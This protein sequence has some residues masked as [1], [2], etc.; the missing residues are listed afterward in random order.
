MSKNRYPIFLSVAISICVVVLNFWHILT[1]WI[2]NPN[3]RTFTWI[4]HY[5][6]DFFLYVSQIAQGM[7]GNWITS[8]A[9]YTNEY[10][11]DTWVYWPNVLIGKIGSILPF[12]PFELYSFAL[13][14]FVVLL[15]VLLYIIMKELFPKQPYSSLLAFFFFAS[16]SNFSDIP[17]LLT[18]GKFSQLFEMWFS[19]TPA[20]NRF[21]GVPHQTLQTILLLLTI[22]IFSRLV[23]G[24]HSRT[25][26]FGIPLAFALICFVTA[27]ITPIQMLLVCAAIVG[28]LIIKKPAIHAYIS[29][30]IG[31]LSAA[32]GAFVVNHAFDA[33][34]LY[35]AAKMWEASQQVRATPIDL[36][37]A[38]GPIIFFLPF[39]IR[40][41]LSQMT[42]TRLVFLLYGISSFTL[43]ATPLPHALGTSPTRWIHPASF[44]LFYAIAAEGFFSLSAILS[45]IFRT[46][47][48]TSLQR[49]H[50]HIPYILLL[51]YLFNTIPALIAQVYVRSSQ[52][53]ASILF[54]TVNHVPTSAISMF[55]TLASLPDTGV[56]LT[57]PTLPYDAM[58]PI[59]SGKRSFTGHPVH[60]LFPQVKEQ[61]RQQFFMGAMDETTARQFLKDHAIGYIMA[62]TQATKTLP[63]YPFMKSSHYN[64]DITLYE[65]TR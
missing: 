22:Y 45:N 18:T 1:Q 5:Y 31:L 10:I 60:T 34:A 36:F 35:T 16:A 3:G 58:V 43:F 61:L 48:N 38:M 2:Q 50:A 14:V 65:I 4:A 9:M 57:D 39:G 7:R 28:T 53:T 33:S 49:V 55:K 51:L 32:A 25:A 30:G 47:K 17:K 56:V 6:A 37:V 52:E 15:L 24:K 29:I 59:R 42:P 23:T 11:P 26:S 12:S 20:L 40:T 44:V 46:I 13:F 41:F 21:G 54:S 19:P 62:S 64:E 27:T 63:S 8:S